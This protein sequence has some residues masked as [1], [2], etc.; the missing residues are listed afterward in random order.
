MGATMP[1]C[2][3]EKTEILAKVSASLKSLSALRDIEAK[4]VL[5]HAGDEHQPLAYLKSG[6]AYITDSGNNKLALVGP[7]SWLGQLDKSAP[8]PFGAVAADS[9]QISLVEAEKVGDLP[10]DLLRAAGAGLARLSGQIAERQRQLAEKYNSRA[11]Y[12]SSYITDTIGVRQ[13]DIVLRQAL[14][15]YI[16]GLPALPSYIDRLMS[17]LQ[18]EKSCVN[19][20]V[21]VA[22]EDPS[23]VTDILKAVNSSFYG[24]PGHV[25]DFQRAVVLL[26]LDEIFRIAVK[27]GFRGIFPDTEEVRAQ[28]N[29]ALSVSRF[30]FDLAKA[31]NIPKASVASIAGMLHGIG[32]TIVYAMKEDNLKLGSVLAVFDQSK[33]GSLLLRTWNFPEAIWRSVQ[34]HEYPE[35]AAPT[36]VPEN[37]RMQVAVVGLAHMCDEYL[38][39]QEGQRVYDA[40]AEQYLKIIG[41]R[42][43]SIQDLFNK[44]LLPSLKKNGYKIPS[45]LDENIKTKDEKQQEGHQP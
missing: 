44:V 15:D 25:E 39:A 38:T 31:Y 16:K 41:S 32:T 12:L 18:D 29:H 35:F 23:M 22:S 45:A 40:F 19:D 26:G 2:Q 27:T 36:A 8:F 21:A 28:Q 14:G 10:P 4:T 33:I 5:V 17:L 42:E 3:K 1:E 13:T 11:N 37:V 43:T 30:A 20:I 34:Y 6:K 9:C 7:G 24:L